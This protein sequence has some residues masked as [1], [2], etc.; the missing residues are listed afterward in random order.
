MQN[1]LSEKYSSD[2]GRDAFK[3]ENV[4]EQNRL[5]ILYHRRLCGQINKQR[6]SYRKSGHLQFSHPEN[7]H[8]DML[9]ALALAVYAAREL[10]F[11]VSMII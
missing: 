2:K 10:T 6:Y 5:A 7:S 3:T 4:M 9:W 8:D 1:L 11:T